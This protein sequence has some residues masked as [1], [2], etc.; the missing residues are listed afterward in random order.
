MERSNHSVYMTQSIT[1]LKI[2]VLEGALGELSPKIIILV[3]TPPLKSTQLFAISTNVLF[4]IISE[5]KWRD[6]I[7]QYI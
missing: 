3:I 7:I 4:V 1:K 6:Q 5:L 2:R